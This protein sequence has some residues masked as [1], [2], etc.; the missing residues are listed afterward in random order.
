MNPIPEHGYLRL[1]QIVGNRKASPPI[2]P[3]VPVSKASW[4]RGVKNGRYPKPVKLTMRT[5]VWHSEEIWALLKYGP[6]WAK[7]LAKETQEGE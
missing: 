6:D 1:S 3:I 4:W 2:P 7:M 5:T